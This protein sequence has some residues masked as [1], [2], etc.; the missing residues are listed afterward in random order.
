MPPKKDVTPAKAS[1]SVVA[2]MTA[3]MLGVP[4]SDN[5]GEVCQA[6]IDEGRNRELCVFL[7]SCHGLYPWIADVA[8]DVMSDRT[9][10]LTESLMSMPETVFIVKDVVRSGPDSLWLAVADPAVEMLGWLKQMEHRGLTHTFRLP[11]GDLSH[12]VAFQ[13]NSCRP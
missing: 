10:P 9:T 8:G 4:A 11:D 3:K 5:L 13:L 12:V 7:R 6:Y 1:E 2:R